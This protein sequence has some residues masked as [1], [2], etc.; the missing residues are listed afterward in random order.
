MRALRSVEP[1]MRSLPVAEA[2]GAASSA[3]VRVEP[4]KV[5][6]PGP[7]IFMPP[8]RS[9]TVSTKVTGVF[10]V[11]LVSSPGA[12]NVKCESAITVG[13]AELSDAWV[14]MSVSDA[15][16]PRSCAPSALIHSIPE[17]D[18]EGLPITCTSSSVRSVIRTR[19]TNHEHTCLRTVMRLAAEPHAAPE[20][21]NVMRPELPV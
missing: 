18:S 4:R 19:A 12:T 6:A 7:L 14:M 17:P 3:A 11:A 16:Q 21:A 5:T 15:V 2:M 10:T 8:T 20:L 9:S 1:S 13:R